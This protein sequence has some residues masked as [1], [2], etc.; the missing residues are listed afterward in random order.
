VGQ[1]ARE[2]L[3]ESAER[4][5]EALASRVVREPQALAGLALVLVQHQHREQ[6]LGVGADDLGSSHA[7]STATSSSNESPCVSPSGASACD[8]SPSASEAVEV[9][10]DDDAVVLV[11][12]RLEGVL[13]TTRSAIGPHARGGRY[14]TSRSV[15]R[16]SVAATRWTS[17]EVE[18]LDQLG[19]RVGELGDE[20]V[21]LSPEVRTPAP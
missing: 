19:E 17:R 15:L 10:R 14:I 2:V 8:A 3:A 4:A 20:L 9:A 13:V 21:G 16:T 5:L 12:Y 6:Q 11:A 7:R 18:A 1:R